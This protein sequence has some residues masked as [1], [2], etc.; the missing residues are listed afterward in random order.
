MGPPP[1]QQCTDVSIV[2]DF[3]LEDEFETIPLTAISLNPNITF[4]QGGSSLARQVQIEIV[5][6]HLLKC[7]CTTTEAFIIL[8][9]LHTDFSFA[10]GILSAL[11]MLFT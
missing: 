1:F 4:T 2:D 11:I 7:Y 8:V 6:M 10:G 3:V 9:Q 5:Q